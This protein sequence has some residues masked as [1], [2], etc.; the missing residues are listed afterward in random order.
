MATSLNNLGLEGLAQFDYY[1]EAFPRYLRGQR[2]LSENTE[3]VYLADLRSFRQYLAKEDLEL[4]DM[5]RHI[6]RAYL[7]WLATE[8][9]DG[10]R[11]FARVSVARKLTVLRT[12]YRFLVQEGLF[13]STPVPSGRS[14]KLKV[15]KTLPS[16]L[17]QREVSRLMDA[18]DESTVHGMRDKAVLE[19]LYACGIRL[20]EL[21]GL[22]LADINFSSREIL[23]RGKGSKE[24]MV[25]FG[26]PS[27]D[28]L[29][30]YIAEA[31]PRLMSRPTQAL[32][33]NRYGERLSRRSLE[34]LV[35]RYSA[36]AGTRADVHPHTL[37]HTFAT[38]ML[39]G[40]ADLRVIQGLLGHSSATTTQIYTHVTQREALT[41]YLSSHPRA[42]EPANRAPGKPSVAGEPQSA[43]KDT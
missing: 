33:L 32:F 30:R 34:K 26:Q 5:D 6:L 1:L 22:D 15:P 27:H 8:G 2:G 36:V 21:H 25:L 20:A 4:T 24:R 40:G 23:V 29:R 39:E 10:E 28:A 37:R 19:T 13:R 18:P 7:A 12:F 42:D 38:H 17:G 35:R 14:F 31:R 43:G 3:R 11:G 41:A 16:F 9:R